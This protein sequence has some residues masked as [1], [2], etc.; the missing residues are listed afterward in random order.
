MPPQKGIKKE[1]DEEIL[2]DEEFVEE[3]DDV[4]FSTE[5]LDFAK[6]FD[7]FTNENI[8]ILRKAFD[9]AFAVQEEEILKMLKRL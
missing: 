1:T 4:V 7:K 2:A 6:D 8:P 5:E 3:A 9:E